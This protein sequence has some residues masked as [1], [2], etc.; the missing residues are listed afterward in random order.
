MIA[1]NSQTQF[2]T[3]SPFGVGRYYDSEGRDCLLPWSTPEMHRLHWFYQPLVLSPGFA[4]GSHILLVSLFDESLQFGPFARILNQAGLVTLNADASFY[5]A[6]RVESIIRL[7][8]PTAIVGVNRAVVEGLDALGFDPLQLFANTVVWAR[9]DAYALLNSRAGADKLTL[10]RWQEMGPAIAME[11]IHGNGMHLDEREW[12]A[13]Q[14]DGTLILTSRL[15]RALN[16]SEFNT[17]VKARVVHHDC[18]CGGG[19]LKIHIESDSE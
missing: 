5:D 11:C 13:S 4:R 15:G 19:G 3:L 14:R 10:R 18:A 1:N 8:K 16:F 17:G 7:F 9:P 2:P 6:K 12:E